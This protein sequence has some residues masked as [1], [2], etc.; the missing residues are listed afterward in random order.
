M[1][2]WNPCSRVRNPFSEPFIPMQRRPTRIRWTDGSI[3]EVMPGSDWLV[4]AR[5]AGIHIPTG[6]LEGRCGACDIEVNGD[7]VRACRASVPA[8]PEGLLQVELTS[9]PHW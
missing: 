7:V 4:V 6:C 8:C 9:D 5:Q 1:S 3:T 2:A